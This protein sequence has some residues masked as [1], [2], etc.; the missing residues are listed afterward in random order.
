[1]VSK[2]LKFITIERLKSR[3]RMEFAEKFNNKFRVYNRA[4]FMISKIFMDSEFHV[5]EKEFLDNDIDMECMAAQKHVPEVE[6]TI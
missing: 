1:M 2:R 6:Q 5:L 4:G 3:A